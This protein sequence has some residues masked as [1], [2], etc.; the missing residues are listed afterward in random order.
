MF[1]GRWSNSCCTHPTPG[2][3]LQAAACRGLKDELGLTV[4][5][6]L[7][8]GSF[9]YR[10]FDAASGM[11]EHERDFVF[12]GVT[13]ISSAVP[14]LDHVGEIALVPFS[15]ALRAT[16]STDGAPWASEVLRRSH[17]RLCEGP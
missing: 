6:L 11:V 13:R 8:A 7:P 10:A 1:A 16:S 3:S 12:V 2:E 17:R 9:T 15:E 4:A 5:E 14:H